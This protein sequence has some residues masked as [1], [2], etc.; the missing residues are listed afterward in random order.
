MGEAKPRSWTPKVPHR[1]FAFSAKERRAR[2]VPLRCH[3][4]SG[5]R[6]DPFVEKRPQPLRPLIGAA[7]EWKW[8]GG[9]LDSGAAVTVVPPHAGAGYA[10]TEG[11]APQAGAKY[12]V[13]NGEEIPFCARS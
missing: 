5:G 12:E 6:L 11:E 4:Q 2:E 9:I 1:P 3:F 8:A 13:A 10:A 7:G